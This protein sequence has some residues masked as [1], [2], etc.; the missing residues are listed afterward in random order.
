MGGVA[1]CVVVSLSLLLASHRIFPRGSPLG[2]SHNEPMESPSDYR[3]KYWT[4]RFRQTEEGN[5]QSPSPYLGSQQASEL[6]HHPHQLRQQPSVSPGSPVSYD[7]GEIVVQTNGGEA[8]PELK[9]ISDQLSV[10]EGLLGQRIQQ[11]ESHGESVTIMCVGESG[12]GKSTLLSNIFTV[13]ICHSC[14]KPTCKI[15]ETSVKFECDGIPITVNLID[16]PGYGDGMDIRANFNSVKSYLEKRFERSLGK[17]NQ[18]ERQERHSLDNTLGVDAILY[19]FSPHRCKEI[20]LEFLKSIQGYATIIPILAKAD[21]MTADELAEFRATVIKRLKQAGIKVFHSPFAIIASPYSVKS[22]TNNRG[23]HV[24]GRQYPW[25][26]AE[27]EN[28]RHSDLPALRRCLIT[29]GLSELHESTRRYYEAYRTEQLRKKNSVWSRI[30]RA[31]VTFLQTAL[32]LF[33]AR[34]APR[35]KDDIIGEGQGH[36]DIRVYDYDYDTYQPE[37]GPSLPRLIRAKKDSMLRLLS[38]G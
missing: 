38:R 13:P 3:S 1:A 2:S 21:T 14:P 10:R 5:V 24:P 26:V 20:D 25:G 19:F 23:Y 15:V 16:T 34:E 17:E 11:L 6:N 27:S 35:L 33:A 29:E 22:A 37:E 30:K 8:M 9:P 4:A 12:V 32:L 36:S 18:I 31:A 7:A 28:E